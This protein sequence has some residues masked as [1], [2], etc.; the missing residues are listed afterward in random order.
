MHKQVII[1]WKRHKIQ[2]GTPVWLAAAAV[3]QWFPH[4]CQTGHFEMHTAVLHRDSLL[5]CASGLGIIYAV[6][7]GPYWR[8]SEPRCKSERLR[9]RHVVVHTLSAYMSTAEVWLEDCIT[10]VG[11]WMSANRVKFNADQMELL[12]A[13][14]KYGLASFGWLGADVVTASFF[15]RY[16]DIVRRQSREARRHCLSVLGVSTGWKESNAQWMPSR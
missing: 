13:G 5:L 11:Q 15:A 9:R 16:H 3:W 2:F 14:S 6:L 10:E 8:C 7:S 12:W 1:S 4:I